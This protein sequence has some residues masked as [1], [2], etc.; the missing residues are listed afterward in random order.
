[1]VD[2]KVVS[3]VK[4]HVVE[5]VFPE[6]NPLVDGSEVSWGSAALSAVGVPAADG[7]GPLRTRAEKDG[8]Y[9]MQVVTHGPAQLYVVFRRVLVRK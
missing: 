8:V 2:V 5:G 3:S 1:M 9:V 6:L 7:G 4:K